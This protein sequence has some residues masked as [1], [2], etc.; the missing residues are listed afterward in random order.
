MPD[1]YAIKVQLEGDE[2]RLSVAASET[3]LHDDPT[4]RT[5]Q[6]SASLNLLDPAALV[7]ARGLLVP[8]TRSVAA[9]PPDSPERAR[10]AER[11]LAA[12]PE[13]DPAQIQDLTSELRKILDAYR[14]AIA[15][16]IRRAAVTAEQTAYAN[17]T[18]ETD[19]VDDGS[20]L[21]GD[22]TVEMGVAR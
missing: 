4:L 15:R 2:L 17:D 12:V 16:L 19:A 6:V 3:Y 10:L 14:S 13:P 9:T 5:R 8:L 11:R 20:G 18:D 1:T 7:S 22:V 21:R